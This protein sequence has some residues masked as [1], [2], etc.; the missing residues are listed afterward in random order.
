MLKIYNG[1]QFYKNEK[2]RDRKK[3]ASQQT[4]NFFQCST[5][6]QKMKL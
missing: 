2:Q 4:T 3:K 5:K 1:Q 6:M